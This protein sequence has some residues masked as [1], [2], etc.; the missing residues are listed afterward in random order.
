MDPQS[1]SR[2]AILGASGGVG[3]R[4]VVRALER[5]FGV[6]GQTRNIDK[7]ADLRDQIKILA[8][9]PRDR[10]QLKKF[11]RGADAAI[12]ALGVDKLG[13][14]TLFSEVTACL[15]AAM[16]TEGV[17][18]LIAITGV[19]AGE[20]R[21]HGGFLYDRIIFPLFTQKIYVDKDR[22][23][24]LIVASDLEWTIVRPAPF[25][26]SN[27][28]DPIEIHTHLAASTRL[29]RITRDEVAEFVV[30][31]LTC[32]RFLRQKPFIGHG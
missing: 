15:I 13:T 18:R 16:K 7:L 6:I 24:A 10:A 21:G 8:F 29:R 27:V 2:V 30:E 9:E 14:T 4:I 12:F 19:G 32:N 25:T 5:G 20:T 23:E 1:V 17:R 22:Q 3:R 28:I 11:L 31:Q 26:I